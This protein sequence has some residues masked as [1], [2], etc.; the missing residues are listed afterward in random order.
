METYRVRWLAQDYIDAYTEGRQNQ[1]LEFILIVLHNPLTVGGT[2]SLQEDVLPAALVI[3]G[4]QD[5]LTLS[6]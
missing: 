6:S 1:S 4:T 2:N 5:T 3:Q